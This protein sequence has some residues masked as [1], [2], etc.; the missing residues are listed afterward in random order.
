MSHHT[1]SR[2]LN[3]TILIEEKTNHYIEMNLD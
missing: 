1:R 2:F 3:I